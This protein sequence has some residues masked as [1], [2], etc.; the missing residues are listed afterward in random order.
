MLL[1]YKSIENIVG[2]GEIA[3]FKRLVLQTCMLLNWKSLKLAYWHKGL[4]N[5]DPTNSNM[6]SVTMFTRG[7]AAGDKGVRRCLQTPQG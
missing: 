3:C 5:I 1:E 4:K 7:E 6:F 2:K